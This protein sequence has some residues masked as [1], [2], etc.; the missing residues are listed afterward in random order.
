M[1]FR[2]TSAAADLTPAV[3]PATAF[4]SPVDQTVV[5][6][7]QAG[8]GFTAS[9]GSSGTQGDTTTT[10]LLGSQAY[11]LGPTNGAGGFTACRKT[12]IGPY[13]A[14]GLYLAMEARVDNWQYLADCRLDVSSDVFTNWS[15]G[16][17]VSP[18]TNLTS[19]YYVE[20]EWLY[21]T[22]NQ[23]AFA[24]GGGAGANFGA[25]TAFQCRC[26]DN[27]SGKVT[28]YVNKISLIAPPANGVVV[29]TFDDGYAG[30]W[31]NAKPIFDQAGIKACFGPIVNKLG[32]TNFMTV[33][34]ARL[35]RDDGWEPM[36]HAY[37]VN[38]HNNYST[39]SDGAAIVDMQAAKLWLRQNG[40]GPADNLLVPQGQILNTTRFE[41]FRKLGASVRSAYTRVR[42]T[43]PPGSP[44]DV[45][46]YTLSQANNLADL[47]AKVDECA[48]NK[49]M[50]VLQAHDIETTPSQ[51]TSWS[52][53]DLQSLV[54]YI[55][56]KPL[57]IRR[58]V[59]VQLNGVT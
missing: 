28:M 49:T 59:D 30:V 1:S 43:Y 13:N 44:Y 42:E 18:S 24:V 19:P 51:Q 35:L 8:H 20:G 22:L 3:V 27:G 54:N 58:M 5:T 2:P 31:S 4:T 39:V 38:V 50:L 7:F 16:D 12:G 11:K 46:T 29:F 40:F 41:A 15:S 37:D 45:R 47:Q 23:G 53:A 57:P 21:V 32:A 55:L 10:F 9:P 48:T 25:L 56:A 52:T 36:S 26:K 14:T 34:Q 6:L 33:A 17:T